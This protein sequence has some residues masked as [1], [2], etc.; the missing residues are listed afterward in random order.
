[1]LAGR[2]SG[3]LCFTGWDVCGWSRST[4]D[5]AFEGAAYSPEW[6]ELSLLDAPNNSNARRDPPFDAVAGGVGGAQTQ[7][8]FGTSADS[9]AALCTHS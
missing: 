7:S 3:F 6:S 5:K 9:G 4:S 1:M 2:A 8:T